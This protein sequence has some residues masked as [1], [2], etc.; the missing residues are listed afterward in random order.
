MCQK[1]LVVGMVLVVAGQAW[2]DEKDDE[3]RALKGKIKLLEAQ[4]DVLRLKIE[5][6]QKRIEELESR[7]RPP[8]TQP[9]DDPGASAGDGESSDSGDGTSGD[10]TPEEP[11]PPEKALCFTRLTDFRQPI[12]ELPEHLFPPEGETWDELRRKKANEWFTDNVD[13]CEASLRLTIASWKEVGPEGDTRFRLE[14][15]TE[16]VESFRG[17]DYKYKILAYVPSDRAERLLRHNPKDRVVVFGLVRT[18]EMIR[19]KRWIEKKAVRDRQGRIRHTREILHLE[20]T[21]ELIL[22][23][24]H[25]Q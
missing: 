9:A 15:D 5:Q 22:E 10:G 12:R 18:V 16:T 11:A 3:I 25:V 4:I 6:Q 23:D 2:A 21:M 17:I 13:G 14:F 7:P 8:T 24:C 1:L 20:A 19:A